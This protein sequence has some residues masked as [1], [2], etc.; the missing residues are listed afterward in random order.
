MRDSNILDASKS[1]LVVVDMQEAFRS[2]I[3]DFALIASRIPLAVRGFATLGVPIIVT[4]QYPKGLGRTIEE[5]TLSLPDGVE[6]IEKSAF[7]ACGA[8]AFN[9][10]L[11]KL[12]VGQV[13]ICGIETHVCVNQTTHD[14]LERDYDV[15]VLTDCVGAR[16]EHDQQAGLKKMFAR[17]AVSSSVEMAL[18][19]LMRDSGHEKFKE[20]QSL[21]R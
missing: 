1:T 2:V 15:H 17:G 6:I 7:S 3:G 18:F 11:Q 13:A 21:I 16:F 10:R 8:E 20:V 12:G 14:L 4:E 5:I 19:E 9:D